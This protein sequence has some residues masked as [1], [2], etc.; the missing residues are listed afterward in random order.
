MNPQYIA[1]SLLE[2]NEGTTPAQ[3][4]E[5]QSL[6]AHDYVGL[7]C[8][9]RRTLLTVSPRRSCSLDCRH[10]HAWRK[11]QLVLQSPRASTP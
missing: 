5:K 4:G 7:S 6:I 8:A 10:Y 1:Q 3:Q 9:L 11:K 2:D